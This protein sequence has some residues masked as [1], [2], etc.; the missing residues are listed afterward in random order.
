MKPA[1]GHGTH[2]AGIIGA[3]QPTAANGGK[4]RRTQIVDG[5]C[6]DIRLYDF[7]VLGASS[8][9]EDTEFAII[10]ALQYIRYLNES[11]T[12]T[13]V[14][15]ANLSLAIP[16][17]VRNF[18]CGRTPVCDECERLVGSGVVVVVAAGNLGYHSFETGEG[19]SRGTP[20]SASPIRATPTKSSRSARRTARGR[21]PTA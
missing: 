20:R 16:H 8:T 12:F 13:T 7:K 1:S 9:L 4:A 10:A 6:P 17:D 3:R 11:R 5:M 21:T 19:A 15:G 18:A 2:V 14:H